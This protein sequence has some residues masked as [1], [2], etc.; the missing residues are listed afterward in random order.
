MQKCKKYKQNPA[1]TVD[2]HRN[3]SGDCQ[4]CVYFSKANC[5]T[6]AANE[7]SQVV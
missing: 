1:S 3:P 7:V 4:S 2:H 5:G 6:H